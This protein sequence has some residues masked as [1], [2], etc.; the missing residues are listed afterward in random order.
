MSGARSASPALLPPA[1]S[2]PLD[3][4]Q[5]LESRVLRAASARAVLV[6][7]KTAL[8]RPAITARQGLRQPQELHAQPGITVLEELVTIEH[9]VLENMRLLQ[10][11]RVSP[12]APCTAD[13]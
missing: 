1:S 2:V 3:H 8:P 13:S 10:P 12:L 11:S 5:R 4:C 9:V 7:S 6:A